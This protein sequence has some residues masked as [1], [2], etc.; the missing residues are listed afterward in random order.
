MSEWFS[1][2]P[3]TADLHRQ[4]KAS[5]LRR[6]TGDPT[7]G[8]GALVLIYRH[9]ASL[10][11]HWQNS[12][13]GP[14]RSG[15]LQ[16]KYDLLLSHKDHGHLVADWRLRGLESEDLS[17]WLETGESPRSIAKAPVISPLNR[18]VLLELFRALPNLY[19]S[20]QDLELHA[21]LFCGHPDDELMHQLQHRGEADALLEDWCSSGLTQQDWAMDDER[22]R[23][24]ESELEHYL[25][26]SREQ[27]RMLKEQNAIG[28]RALQLACSIG[29]AT[30]PT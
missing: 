16:K 9:P 20:Y 18:L 17:R 1:P 13:A 2:F 26:L 4:L 5:G 30:E 29:N 12:D 28:D 7:A 10:L 27:Q 6:R 8:E 11:Q 3:L 19:G 22:I 23:R 24:L 14:L 25:L 21:E 15:S